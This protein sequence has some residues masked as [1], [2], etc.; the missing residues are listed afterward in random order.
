MSVVSLRVLVVD[1]HPIFRRG[2]VAVLQGAGY[3]V[4]AEA[5]DGVEALALSTRH[6]PIDV[7]VVDV[8]MAGMDGLALMQAWQERGDLPRVLMLSLHSEPHVVR[9]ALDAGAAGYVLKDRAVD[10]LT[11]AIATV[12]AGGRFVSPPLAAALLGSDG[13]AVLTAAELRIVGLLADNLTSGEIAERLGLS[14]HTVQNHRA[15]AASKLGLSGPNRLL[16]FALE[17]RARLRSQSP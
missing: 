4:V 15:H 1:D 3:T 7:A 17:R 2:L 14:A 5:S 10:E 13:L 8:A 6:G 11:A 12:V 9:A 16:Q